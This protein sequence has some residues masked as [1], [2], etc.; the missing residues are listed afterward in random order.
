MSTLNR[1]LWRDIR[2][3]RAQF[4]AVAVTVFLGVTMFVASY[5]SYLNLDASYQATFTEYRF[6]NVTY[7][8]GDVEKLAGLVSGVGGVESVTVRTVADQPLR[9]GSVKMLGRVVGVP[10]DLQADVNQLKVLEGSY[11]ATGSSILV[12]EHMANHFDLSPGDSV[13]ILAGDDW[14][15]APVAGIVSSP[16]YIWPA[17][18]RQELIT[19]PDNFGVVFATEETTRTLTATGPNELAV[20]FEGGAENDGLEE[21][22]AGIAAGTGATADYTRDEQPSNAALAEDIKGFEEMAGFFPLL[23]LTAAGLASYVMIS[24]LVH[25]QRPH[26]GAMLANGMTK[27]KVLRHYLGYGVVPGLIAAIPGA[28][29]GALLAR[30]ITTFYTGLLSVPVTLIEFYP[31]NAIGGILF[32]VG[33]AFLAALAPALVAS[34]IRPAEAM[35]GE[36]P[37]GGGQTSLLE[38]VIPP[39]RRL[40]IRWRM[41]LRG[42]GRN[43]RRTIYTVVGVVLSLMLV[44]VSWGMIDTISHLMNT[45]FVDIQQEDATVYFT[46]PVG[47]AEIETLGGID[48]VE[49]VEASLQIPVRLVAEVENYDTNLVSLAAATEMHRFLST[50]GEWLD[51]GSGLLVG[52]AL[53]DLLDVEIGDSIDVQV[54]LLGAS[55]TEEIAGFLDEP[56]GT[57]AYLSDER[58]TEIAGVDLP[59]T[60][61]LIRY[62]E[63]REGGD[64]RSAITELPGVAAFN[65]SKAMFDMMQEFM[66]LFYAFVG[67]M[68]VF[69]GAMAFALI[70]N[71]M[72]VN[73][74]ERRREVAT[75][76]A[77]GTDRKTIS[78]L[79]TTEN[80]I[81]AVMGIPIGLVAGYY[82]SKAALGT[83]SS[84]M[85]SFDLYVRPMTFVWASLAIVV[86]ALVSQI[87]G[88]RAVR[89]ISIPQIIKERAA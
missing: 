63:G 41:P 43:P 5:D 37:T 52:K 22:L 68:L 75:L 42:I 87:P 65:D 46:G 84:D 19:T 31:A 64:L 35:R 72:S 89:R 20:Y 79:I 70:F 44:L 33:A 15:S 23:F 56:L 32:G 54:G 71:A 28:I 12:E 80:L 9:I 30:I 50:D 61:A 76:L 21:Q 24:R 49:V 73:I 59:A 57:L 58:L 7:V 55:F 74:A 36:T 69:G 27:R 78:R 16:E 67:V 85:F 48:G 81:V 53:G 83:F 45:Q 60:S 25:A 8:G 86:V 66:L 29:A 62:E 47:D 34:R 38:R 17:R 88:L 18:N 2:R 6:A 11:L 39:L 77:V 14:I 82:L 13:D 1:K 3:H 40:P 26:I 4:I 51:L 10:A